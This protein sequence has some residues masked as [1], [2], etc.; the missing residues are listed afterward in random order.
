MSCQLNFARF[1]RN[2][3]GFRKTTSNTQVIGFTDNDTYKEVLSK[4][5]EGLGLKYDSNLLAMICS[6]GMI[7]NSLIGGNPWTLG[8]FI[9]HNGGYQNR[10]KKVFEILIPVGYGEGEEEMST[11]DS[12]S[13]IIFIE[14]TT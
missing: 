8:E 14:I 3:T 6:G 13:R 7:T 10:A 12:V 9:K 5:C 4:A 11:S 2:L 1:R